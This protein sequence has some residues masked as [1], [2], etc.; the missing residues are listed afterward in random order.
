[1]FPILV[2]MYARLALTEE[3]EVRA[4]FGIEYERYAARTPR[5]VPRLG[6]ARTPA[7]E[8]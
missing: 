8:A 6:G 2:F 5:F 3:R 4:Q 7:E 1:M